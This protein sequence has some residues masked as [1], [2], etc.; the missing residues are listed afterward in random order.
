V[1]IERTI[2]HFYYC[3]SYSVAL[4]GGLCQMYFKMR[5]SFELISQHIVIEGF[6]T[7]LTKLT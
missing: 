3:P 7:K 6:F 1:G 5:A 4:I 2:G